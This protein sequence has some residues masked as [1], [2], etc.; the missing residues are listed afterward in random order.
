[1]GSRYGVHQAHIFTQLN[2]PSKQ[3]IVPCRERRQL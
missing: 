2:R 1:L 3:K